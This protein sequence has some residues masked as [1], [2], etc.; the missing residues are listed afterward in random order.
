MSNRYRLFTVQFAI[1]LWVMVAAGVLFAEA[2]SPDWF[3]RA[4][5]AKLCRDYQIL[6][7][8]AYR[9]G[10][11]AN[12]KAVSRI[13][14]ISGIGCETY[15]FYPDTGNG[16][17]VLIQEASFWNNEHQCLAFNRLIYQLKGER[18]AKVMKLWAV[19][20]GFAEQERGQRDVGE[21]H[22]WI[23]FESNE[24]NAGSRVSLFPGGGDV[25]R[26]LIAFDEALAEILTPRSVK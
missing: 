11:M 24:E 5:L 26:R 20:T 8:A 12:V 17:S 16:M 10:P 6:P 1:T 13:V 23:V 7:L 18:Q 4:G 3:L 25:G 2:A 14:E 15:V 21:D 22:G 9:T 19:T